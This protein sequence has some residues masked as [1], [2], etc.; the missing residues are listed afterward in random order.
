MLDH[1]KQVIERLKEEN[2]YREFLDISRICGEFPYAINHQNNQKIV[3]WCSNDYV[4]AGQNDE[5]IKKAKEALDQYGVGAGGT[6][7]ISGNSH[8]LVELEKEIADLHKKEA[9]LSFVSGYVANDAT[10][11][12][13]AKILPDLVIFSDQ[14]NHASIITGIRNSKAQKEIFRHN[15]CSHLEE[16]LQKY[17]KN[18]PKLIIFEAVY[19]MDGDFGEI[20]KFIDLAQKYGALTFIDEVHAVG[21]YGKN[22][23]G[24]SE[25]LGLS[26]QIDII[27]GT[28]AKAF[29]TIGGYIAAKKEIVDAIRS[30]ASGFI[31]TT[32]LPPVIAAATIANIKKAKSDDSSRKKLHENVRLLKSKIADSSIRIVENKSHIISVI[33]GDAARA[34]AISKRLLDEFNIYV[35]HIN[36][37]TVAKG[38]ERLRITI[39]PFHSEKMID[40]LVSA[41]K[42]MF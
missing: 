4:G 31:F 36:Y 13:L 20:K 3:V 1:F 30:V 26:D 12:A 21:L 33:V 29:G 22:G 5:A 19:S 16:L 2:R 15:D 17:P 9:A 11:Q 27:Q 6:R 28:C 32:A 24:L 37:P 25:E 8:I 38:D 23:A 14:K 18:Q 34:K 39:T 41:L 42:K 10:I 7:N 40:E 35:Q